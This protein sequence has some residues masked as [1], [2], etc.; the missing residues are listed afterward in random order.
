MVRAPFLISG[1]MGEEPHGLQTP[2][3]QP[4][5]PG[6]KGDLAGNAVDGGYPSMIAVGI[7]RILPDIP[8]SHPVDHPGPITR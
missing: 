2:C 3:K 7:G 1:I 5:F 8:F 4:A 6:W